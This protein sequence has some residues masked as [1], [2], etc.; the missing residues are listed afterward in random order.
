MKH[1]KAGNLKL[2]VVAPN[3][4]KVQSKGGLDDAVEKLKTACNLI[5]PGA[6]KNDPTPIAFA[7]SR[8]ALGRALNRSVPISTIGIR[9]VVGFEKEYKKVIDLLEASKDRYRFTVKTIYFYK[10]FLNSFVF[11]FV[12]SKLY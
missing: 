4:E 10:C 2:V 5:Q 12:F 8:I 11:K 7:L 3:L 1:A 6:G 9:S